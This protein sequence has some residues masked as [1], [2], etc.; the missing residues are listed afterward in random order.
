MKAVWASRAAGVGTW[1]QNVLQTRCSK[2]RCRQQGAERRIGM[3]GANAVVM[4][5]GHADHQFTPPPTRAGMQ[6]RCRERR[7]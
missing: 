2:A 1:L 4:Y 5:R 7:P 3:A 6:A